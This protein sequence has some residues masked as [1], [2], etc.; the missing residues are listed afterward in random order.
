MSTI[1]V[2]IADDHALLTESLQLM[3]QQD[4]SIQVVGLAADGDEA[5][6]MCRRL[7][8]DVVLM[9]IKMLKCDGFRATEMI[10]ETLPE[11][12]VIFL[13]TFEGKENIVS[14]VLSGADGYVLKDATPKKLILAIKCV[15]SGFQVLQSS[16][17]HVLRHELVSL[18]NK[19]K[20]AIAQRLKPE[21]LKIIRLISDGKNNREIAELMNYSEGTIKNKISRILEIL[22]VKD[23]TQLVVYALKNDLI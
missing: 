8:P 17:S 2:L 20:E 6:E 5:V 15:H 10:K 18:L 22:E 4:D 21:E 23:R 12:K 1:K 11:T 3:L 19:G 16:V 7:L 14:A 13:T 9:D